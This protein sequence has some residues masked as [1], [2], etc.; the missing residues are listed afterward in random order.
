MKAHGRDNE[1]N[2]EHK[3]GHKNNGGKWKKHR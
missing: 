1:E 3:E 2:L